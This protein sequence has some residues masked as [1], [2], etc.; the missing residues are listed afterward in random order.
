M[1]SGAGSAV[2]GP[3]GAADCTLELTDDDWIAMASG[4]ADPMQLYT[5]Q[6]L[7]ISGDLM[8]SQKLNFLKKIDPTAAMEAIARVRSG[9]GGSSAP[10][11]S[12]G[13]SVTARVLEALRALGGDAWSGLEATVAI[14]I[15]DG[16]KSTFTLDARGV[17]DGASDART[18][19]SMTEETLEELARG[20][21]LRGLYQRGLV[22]V[23][24]PVGPARGLT[25][26]KGL[27]T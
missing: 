27:L 4:K 21:D 17:T 13:P 18:T 10:K 16:A 6:K 5:T 24:G 14:A 8:A 19:V 22:R 23:D 12:A 15:T 20:G 11:A 26:F 1:K 3:K 9:G 25:L 2:A 7:K